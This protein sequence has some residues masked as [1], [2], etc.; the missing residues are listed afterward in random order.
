MIGRPFGPV[1]LLAFLLSFPALAWAQP[2]T[3]ADALLRAR[4][5]SPSITGAQ[6]GLEAA[7]G[8]AAQAGVSPNPELQVSV[9][10]FAGSGPFR[11]I[12]GTEITVGLGQRFERGGKR[13]ARRSFAA[14]ELESAKLRLTLAEAELDR[15]VRETFAELITAQ[16]RLE[17]AQRNAEVA[18]TLAATADIL[19]QAGR[20]PPLRALRARSAAILSRAEVESARAVFVQAGRALAA[21]IGIEEDVTA[22][23]AAEIP[24][25]F[26][27]V[28][29]GQALDVRIASAELCA[30]Q[31]RVALEEAAA[32][33]DVTAQAGVR[34]LNET[35]DIALVVGF[36]LPI[37]VRDRNR[38][39]IAAARAEER[40][41]AA[42]LA[43]ATFDAARNLSDARTQE[44][45]ALAR[46]AA[47][48]SSGIVQAREALRLA[49]LGYRAGKFGLL[50]VLE[51]QR[52]LTET[53]NA[54]LDARLA[55]ARALAAFARATAR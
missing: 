20:D 3:L 33:S 34:R 35:D 8:R 51:A 10:N 2:M 23:D 11:G 39:G 52:A 43:Q 38:G 25:Q 24:P 7:R 15:R 18:A 42:R 48:E 44:I 19:V 55:R 36:S 30:A 22:L 53:E 14:A 9:E 1:L 50:D 31:A 17:L 27:A 13:G 5:T 54:L 41:A 12:G 45:A 32:V 26:Q 28:E 47:L 6:A 49:N 46:V 37:A 4:G 16:G 40:A 29:P 21:T